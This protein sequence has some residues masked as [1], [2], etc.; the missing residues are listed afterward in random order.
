[1]S[2]QEYGKCPNGEIFCAN[3]TDVYIKNVQMWETNF[4]QPMKQH[5][6]RADDCPLFCKGTLDCTA[7]SF[8]PEKNVQPVQI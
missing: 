3:K 7:V 6:G 5:Y 2:M 8:D 1:M 4:V